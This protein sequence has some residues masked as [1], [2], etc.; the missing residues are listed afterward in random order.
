M[1]VVVTVLSC[2][3]EGGCQC[4]ASASGTMT[5]NF[6]STAVDS[7]LKSPL[8]AVPLAPAW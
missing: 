4:T 3:P 8:T 7:N 6:K 1:T 5:G 2:Q